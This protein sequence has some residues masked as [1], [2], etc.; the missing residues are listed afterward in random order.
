MP[1]PTSTTPEQE[2]SR[3]TARD[4]EDIANIDATTTA[5][6]D[7]H[8]HAA[9]ARWRRRAGR[10]R[11]RARATTRPAIAIPSPGRSTAR[12]LAGVERGGRRPQRRGD[13]AVPGQVD[14]EHE[15]R[16]DRVERAPR[17][18]PMRPR[19][20][21]RGGRA[22]GGARRRRGHA[23]SVGLA[24]SGPDP[25]FAAAELVG[26]P[27]RSG[28]PSGSCGCGAASAGFRD[29]PGGGSACATPCAESGRIPLRE[30]RTRAL[31]TDPSVCYRHPGRQSWVL[32]QRCG[33][34]VCPECQI[35]A[36]VGVHCPDA[37]RD[38]RRRLLA[39]RGHRDPVQSAKRRRPPGRVRHVLAGA[40]A[41]ARPC[42]ADRRSS[43]TRRS[44]S[45]AC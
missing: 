26:R 43:P 14:G 35:V 27:G 7:G 30:R 9:A 5:G 31:E 33:R 2:R 36:P 15:R 44:T 24:G 29:G 12:H 20:R 16:D 34:T 18:S 39:P 17:P 6:V 42:V 23:R 45:S 32:C 3:G 10:A 22:A 13:D 21:R 8:R 4:H 11:A 37:S 19:P 40:G 38:L 41:P 25:L 28:A 1:T